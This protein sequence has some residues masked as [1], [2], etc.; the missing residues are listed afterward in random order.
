M[1]QTIVFIGVIVG[2][3]AV[4]GG[5]L[6]ILLIIKNRRLPEEEAPAPK[7][8]DEGVKA[9]TLTREQ[10]EEL[11]RR[12]EAVEKEIREKQ[13]Q[14]KRR[15]FLNLLNTSEDL[16]IRFLEIAADKISITD[17]YGDEAPAAL[18]EEIKTCIV[19]IAQRD[20]VSAR[21]IE[22]FSQQPDRSGYW[23]GFGIKYAELWSTL[24]AR[25]RTYLKENENKLKSTIDLNTLTDEDYE[26]RVVEVLKDNGY[27]CVVWTPETEVH[28][29]YLVVKKDN[30]TTLVL[31]KRFQ[32][33]IGNQ[34]VENLAVGM[35]LHKASEGW[36]MTTSGF[37]DSASALAQ[38]NNIRLT[39]MMTLMKRSPK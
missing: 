29:A 35:S 15:E 8:A 14:E 7:K 38:K 17:A 37:A 16:I 36:I 13:Q 21:L 6:K 11:N 1:D 39:N 12:M 23:V 5:I 32:G 27:E 33:D 4:L 26:A 34:I 18:N 31:S 22:E 19:K 24:E 9:K 2:G 28:S 30:K 10:V 25:F 20:G 3:L